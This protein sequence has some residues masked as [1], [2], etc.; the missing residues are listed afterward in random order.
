M[1]LPQLSDDNDA[2]HDG[3]VAFR[4]IGH[5]MIDA[6]GHVLSI[7]CTAVPKAGA[8]GRDTVPY[9][10]STRGE[11]LYLRIVYLTSDGNRHRVVGGDG[12]GEYRHVALHQFLF[13]SRGI[14]DE[15]AKALVRAEDHFSRARMDSNT[16]HVV[17]Q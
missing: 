8:A 10:L 17:A 13:G 5:D 14:A 11:Y 3:F 6:A 16:L 15:A 9:E 2:R 1:L 7:I 12:V 4:S